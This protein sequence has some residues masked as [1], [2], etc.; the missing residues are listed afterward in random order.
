[1]AN[2][3]TGDNRREDIFDGGTGRFQDQRDSMPKANKPKKK[4]KGK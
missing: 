3:K 1:M 4:N 2:K